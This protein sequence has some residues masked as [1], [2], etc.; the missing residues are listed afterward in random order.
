M[1]SA[2]RECAI[3]RVANTDLKDCP[4]TRAAKTSIVAL[5][6]VT[7][8]AC[9]PHGAA[10]P[11]VQSAVAEGRTEAG[12]YRAPPVL[13]K[14]TPLSDGRLRLTGAAAAGARVRL[15]SPAGQP[16]YA[17][18]DGQGVWRIDAPRPSEPRLYGLA[19]ID[20]DRVVQSEGYLVLTGDGA[21]AQLRAGAGATVLGGRVDAPVIDAIDYDSKGGTV[22]SGRAAPHAALDLFVDGARQAGGRADDDGHFALALDEPQ[23]FADHVLAIADGPRH[24]QV[25]SRLTIAPPL[26]N[27]PYRA[28]ATPN[29]WRLDWVTP[30]GGLQTTLLLASREGAV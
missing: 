25:Q 28:L 10:Q 29:G 21:A 30:G 9:Q 20:G 14:A 18:A 7:L 3:D 12:A 13:L 8:G 19:M 23:A 16:L 22:V 11:A 24:I 2:D 17:Q 5:A 1:A 27:G 15:A 26:A 4:I 6:S